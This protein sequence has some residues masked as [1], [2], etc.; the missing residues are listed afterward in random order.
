[1]VA[2]REKW[3]EDCFLTHTRSTANVGLEKGSKLEN[4]CKCTCFVPE[5]TLT[6]RFESRSRAQSDFSPVRAS[7]DLEEYADMT[8]SP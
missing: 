5:H 4:M 6:S 1:M 7:N 2:G 3:D 8:M